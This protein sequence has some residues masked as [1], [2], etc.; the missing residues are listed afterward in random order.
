L[1]AWSTLH[2]ENPTKHFLE[3][4]FFVSSEFGSF[5]AQFTLFLG[6]VRTGQEIVTDRERHFIEIL[7]SFE[8]VKF[9]VFSRSQGIL[10]CTEKKHNLQFAQIENQISIF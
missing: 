9:Q 7:E 10:F 2:L 1:D 6:H 3:A 5:V 4:A 8:N